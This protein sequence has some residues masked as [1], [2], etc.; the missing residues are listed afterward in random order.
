MPCVLVQSRFDKEKHEKM[1]LIPRGN[2]KSLLPYR[3]LFSGTLELIK[4]SEGQPKKELDKIYSIDGDVV[5]ARRIG[6]LPRG[7]QDS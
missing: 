4:N 5:H 2:S 3:R 1:H 6:E 7:P